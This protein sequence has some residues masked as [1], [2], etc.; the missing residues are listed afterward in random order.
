[1]KTE[2]HHAHRLFEELG[3]DGLT[4]VV[5]TTVSSCPSGFSSKE[6]RRMEGRG[7]RGRWRPAGVILSCCSQPQLRIA[8]MFPPCPRREEE[9]LLYRGGEHGG[10]AW[11]QQGEALES[12]CCR[13][14]RGKLQQREG[15][16][17]EAAEKRLL[18]REM[19]GMAAA[20]NGLGRERADARVR[21]RE[22]AW[23]GEVAEKLQPREMGGMGSVADAAVREKNKNQVEIKNRRDGFL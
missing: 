21:L 13:E 17:G 2:S 8:A 5:C 16:Q 15:R 4:V 6:V 3:G 9:L 10:E 19:G 23:R 22:G 7:R 11:Q 14:R 1:M 12:G 18:Q 20:G